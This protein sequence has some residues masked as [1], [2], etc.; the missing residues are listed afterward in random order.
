MGICQSLPSN[1]RG[2]NHKEAHQDR[3]THESTD[4]WLHADRN[5]LP[6]GRRGNL[7]DAEEKKTLQGNGRRL[8]M[9]HMFSDPPVLTEMSRIC[10]MQ[11]VYCTGLMGLDA[12]EKSCSTQDRFESCPGS[13]PEST[14]ICR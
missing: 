13:S 6:A 4:L 2:G 1:E 10:H 3:S 8:R 5:E 14:P 12:K 7:Q 11:S 9:A